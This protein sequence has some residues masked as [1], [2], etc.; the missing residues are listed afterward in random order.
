MALTALTLVGFERR[1]QSSKADE[2]P[3]AAVSDS[4]K[5]APEEKKEG[6]GFRYYVF[7]LGAVLLVCVLQAV[8]PHL[9][10]ASSS[11]WFSGVHSALPVYIG[12]WQTAIGRGG[13]ERWWWVVG[14]HNPARQWIMSPRLFDYGL[15]WLAASVIFIAS[16][17]A[18]RRRTE[19]GCENDDRAF[20]RV[21]MRLLGLGV[22]W[23][24]IALLWHVAINSARL[25]TVGHHR[26][27]GVRRGLFA[28]LRNWIGVALAASGARRHSSI[29]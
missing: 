25:A 4:D 19:S 9:Y 11:R 10:L 29:A 26:G 2:P 13:F 24:V 7:A 18:V 12:G 5:K 17:P 21:L 16:A 15:V 1:W 27:T 23:C 14:V 20:D 3:A 28:A 6:R 8:M 22:I